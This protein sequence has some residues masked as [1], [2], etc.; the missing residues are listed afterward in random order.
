M[1]LIIIECHALHILFISTCIIYLKVVEIAEKITARY[2][3]DL[4]FYSVTTCFV[5]SVALSQNV[6]K[7]CVQKYMWLFDVLPK[8]ASGSTFCKLYW[9]ARHRSKITFPV[10]LKKWLK[11]G[12]Y[13]KKYWT[14]SH[15]LTLTGLWT[16]SDRGH[17]KFHLVEVDHHSINWQVASYHKLASLDCCHR[18]LASKKFSVTLCSHVFWLCPRFTARLSKANVWVQGAPWLS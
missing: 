3:T 2:W 16:V 4:R 9:M 12:F 1:H 7:K 17:L 10:C 14:Q 6:C 8:I 13:A 18:K 5:L 11:N 15:L